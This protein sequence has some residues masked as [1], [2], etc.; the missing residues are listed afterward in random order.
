MVQRVDAGLTDDSGGGAL[1][2]DLLQER[3]IEPMERAVHVA[4][5]ATNGDGA[6]RL[7]PPLDGTWLLPSTGARCSALA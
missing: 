6:L 7:A 2:V 5:S 3:R 4:Q 1:L